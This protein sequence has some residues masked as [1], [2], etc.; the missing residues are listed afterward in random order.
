MAFAVYSGSVCNHR[1][2]SILTGSLTLT[3][4]NMACSRVFSLFEKIH[5][6][7]WNSA[8]ART[9]SGIDC[10]VNVSLFPVTPSKTIIMMIMLMKMLVSMIVMILPDPDLCPKA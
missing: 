10:S 4:K 8:D 6:W 7:R 2:H 3:E 5:L 9:E 1:V